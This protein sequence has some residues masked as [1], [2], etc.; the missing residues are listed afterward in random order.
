M[1]QCSEGKNSSKNKKVPT[2]PCLKDSTISSTQIEK[3]TRDGSSATCAICKSAPHRLQQIP[4][5]KQCDRVLVRRQHAASDG[6]C[7]NCGHHNPNHSGSSCPEPPGCSK[8]PGHHLSLLHKENNTG[9]HFRPR[10]NNDLNGNANQ[11]NPPAPTMVPQQGAEQG[12]WPQAS[13]THQVAISS[14]EVSIA[15]AQVLMNVVPVT[16]TVGMATPF[17]RM[18]SLIMGALTPSLIVSLLI[19]LFWTGLPSKLVSKQSEAVKNQ[20]RLGEYRS[21]SVLQKGVA[22]T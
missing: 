15:R 17:P 8:C 2:L 9:H 19:C 22:V 11:E 14:T 4:V 21:A 12:I 13:N 6:F 16:V 20:E 3:P 5:I 18:H 10:R 1:T 7:F